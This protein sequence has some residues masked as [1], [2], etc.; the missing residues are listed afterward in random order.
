MKIKVDRLNKTNGE[1]N[2]KAYA[3]VVI[4]DAIVLTGI[5]VMDGN[6]GL[7][8]S[9]PSRQYQQDGETKYADIFFPITKEAREE[10][11]K[12]VLDEYNK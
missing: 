10:L 1:G 2:V 6:K 8:V 12:A 9:M 11:Q 4:D 7:F 3:S 5:R